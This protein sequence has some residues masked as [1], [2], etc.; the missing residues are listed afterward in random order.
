MPCGPAKYSHHKVLNSA[1]HGS[2]DLGFSNN[3][4]V[5]DQP[6]QLVFVGH[7]E[8]ISADQGFG[9][10]TTF[11]TIGAMTALVAPVSQDPAKHDNRF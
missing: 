9:S 11:L 1:P 2:H 4:V 7:A 8:F 10:S 3:D 5:A 6:R